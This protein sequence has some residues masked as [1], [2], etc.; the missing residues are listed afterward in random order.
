MSIQEYLRETLKHALSHVTSFGFDTIGCISVLSEYILPD[1]ETQFTF[2]QTI[3]R[4]SSPIRGILGLPNAS[5]FVE[6]SQRVSI[7]WEAF[8]LCQK[9]MINV[10]HTL[11]TMECPHHPAS[12][13]FLNQQTSILSGIPQ[14]C[15]I[16]NYLLI[17]CKMDARWESLSY[18]LEEEEQSYEH[19]PCSFSK[20][21]NK[22]YLL[23]YQTWLDRKK[24]H[25]HKRTLLC[26]LNNKLPELGKVCSDTVASLLDTPREMKYWNMTASVGLLA[27]FS[28]VF[29]KYLHD[30]LHT[31]ETQ[32]S[33]AQ[34]E[35]V[36]Q[37][38]MYKE[39]LSTI[40]EQSLLYHRSYTQLSDDIVTLTTMHRNHQLV[41]E[42]DELQ[43]TTSKHFDYLI[44]LLSLQ[45]DRVS[46]TLQEANTERDRIRTRLTEIALSRRRVQQEITET[47]LES[48]LKEQHHIMER[49]LDV[50]ETSILFTTSIFK[51]C[52]DGG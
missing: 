38:D 6:L 52:I 49:G 25:D 4:A 47:F 24:V 23:L 16:H 50:T 13:Y 37:E 18:Q 28:Q 43:E 19:Y 29:I 39:E 42:E 36:I 8:L 45:K 17:S 20:L 32:Q 9:G 27:V 15:K 34:M 1:I 14:S 46:Q 31:M 33:V 5:S 3:L 7:T 51:K 35:F 44:D 10:L 30:M 12:C 41:H 40:Y 22:L 11:L 2:L 21:C 26:L 48:I